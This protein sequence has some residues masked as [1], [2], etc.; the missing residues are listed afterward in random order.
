[1]EPDN[2]RGITYLRVISIEPLPDRSRI[3]C[4]VEKVEQSKSAV[5]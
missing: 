4:Q 5:C 1:M 3:A 2:G